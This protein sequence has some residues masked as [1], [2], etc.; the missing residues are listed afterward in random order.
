MP[1][2]AQLSAF[3]EI[4]IQAVLCF[5]LL[6]FFRKLSLRVRP[7]S[8]LSFWAKCKKFPV[9]HFGIILLCLIF[10]ALLLDEIFA[11]QIFSNQPRFMR[12]NI[13]LAFFLLY[14]YTS[15]QL[16]GLP[17]GLDKTKSRPSSLG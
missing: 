15:L 10:V 6:A 5:T 1:H 9:S 14:A 4:F 12:S 11:T 2:D 13:I 17:P 16:D 8:P 3:L 7:A